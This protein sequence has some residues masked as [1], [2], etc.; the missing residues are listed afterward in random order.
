M[1]I[2][3]QFITI[4]LMLAAFAGTASA[5]KDYVSYVDP[6]IG[7]GGHGHVFVGA[8]VPFGALQLGPQNIN[9]GWDWCSGY[10]YSDSIMIGFT[11]THLSGTGCGDLGD[12]NLMPYTGEMRTWRGRQQ[13]IKG[14]ASC[15]Y[16]HEKEKA[17]PGYY[18]VE[19][20][21][22]VGVELTATERVGYH[23]YTF[24]GQDDRR[25]M[26]DLLNGNGS[27]PYEA[28]IRKVDDTTIEGYRFSSGWPDRRKMFFY[29][30]LSRPMT[31]FD[32]FAHDTP[33]K[34]TELQARQVK[35][36]A[37]FG[38]DVDQLLVKLAISSVSCENARIN[39][40]TEAA[41]WDFDQVKAAA[42]EQWNKQLAVVDVEG[43]EEEKTI[44][45]T[46]LY[47]TF[48][49]PA[50]Y[51]DVN[52]D[53]R[54]MDDRIYSDN[55]F[56]NYTTFSLWDTYRQLH[57]MFT[58]IAADR[59]PDMI[60]SML[61]ICDQNGKLPIWP[62][63]M[64][65][66]NTMPGYSSV[67]VIADAYLKGITGFDAERALKAMVK[68]ATNREQKGV[69]DF[70]NY[71]YIPADRLREA[72]S[73][74][75][76]YAVD[77]WGLALMAKKM[78]RTEVYDEFIKRGRS[79]ETLFDKSI[80]KIHPKMADGSWY[81]PYDPF[82]AN[83]RDGV[84]DFTEGNGWQYTFMVPQDPD[85]LVRMHGSDDAFIKN[86]DELFV[87][88]GDLGPGAPPDVS[89]MVGQYAHG[90]EPCHHIPYMYVYAGAQ[91]K[92][93]ALVRKLQKQF[94]TAEPDGYSGNEDCGQM[95]AWHVMSA[96]GM[97]QV[98]PSNGVFVLGSP[99]FRKATIH[100]SNGKTF[101]V[102][103]PAN[104]EANVYIKSARLNGK[105][106]TRAFLT[107]DEIMRGGTLELT[108]SA[109]PN[110]K[111]GTKTADRPVSA[112]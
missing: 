10:H 52:G 17:M 15:Y 35:A 56:K 7:S 112:R 71:G 22:G 79:Y 44:F 3:K 28:Y 97:Y 40:E 55:A 37:S 33:S 68:T 39:L 1:N 77:D 74:N 23:R 58:L 83:H 50:L 80:M 31:D 76:E 54:G 107:Y 95:S 34:G 13:N 88:E 67:P 45:Y 73:V 57:P 9:K 4:G 61:S 66:T 104:S 75:L 85:G 87:A 90:N 29:A 70:M 36:V 32:V 18:A 84:G 93:A 8:S 27:H 16:K 19:L 26:F 98:N 111:F 24:R 41:T 5:Q 94:Y 21:N 86:L 46:A 65:E 96:L 99:S 105:N 109:T 110:K 6:F 81:E 92:T 100:L 59:L 38:T 78:G 60:N 20:E 14:A 43:T 49:A 103:A 82:L 64:E 63:M 48:I 108:M 72:T 12:F 89:G 42:V 91:W 51:C 25:V 106:H 101:T 102:S 47:H 2:R 30:K 53:F 62:L 69:V 11:H